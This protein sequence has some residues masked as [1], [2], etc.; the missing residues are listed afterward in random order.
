MLKLGDQLL[1]KGDELLDV[2]TNI[3]HHLIGCLEFRTEDRSRAFPLSNDFF[4]DY[5]LDHDEAPT[6][7]V[8]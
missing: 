3:I 6:I 8:K 7:R 1:I 5:G 2:I 4:F